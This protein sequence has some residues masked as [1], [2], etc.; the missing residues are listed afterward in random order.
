MYHMH[1][2]GAELELMP[3][4]EYEMMVETLQDVLKKKQDAEKKSY[5]DTDSYQGNPASTANSM[6]RSASSSMPKAPS[7]PS[8]GSFRMPKM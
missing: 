7:M 5:K 4:W 8:P 1:T 3:Y 2:P 6:M